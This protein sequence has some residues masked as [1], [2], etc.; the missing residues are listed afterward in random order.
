MKTGGIFIYKTIDFNDSIEAD[1]L[2]VYIDDLTLNTPEEIYRSNIC[3][4]YLPSI[5]A[6]YEKEMFL[7]PEEQNYYETL[8]FERR[9]KSYLLGRYLVKRAVSAFTKEGKLENIL[10]VKGVFDQPLIRCPYHKNIQTSLT[11]CDDFGAAIVYPDNFSMG[12]DIE[13]IDLNRTSVLGSQITEEEKLLIRRFPYSYV[14]ML[15][16]LWTVK[17]ALSKVLKTGLTTPF[18]VFEVDKV[19]FEYNYIICYFKNFIQY[20][21]ISFALEQYVCSLVYPRRAELFIDVDY[22]KN[23]LV[24]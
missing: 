11:H 12:I 13:K 19:Q 6:M 2:R 3:L 16:Y 15:T 22:L 20:K 21:A 24:F 14:E 1:Y 8:K 10:V 9:K 7:H 18:H 4:G 23:Y 17:E 5:I